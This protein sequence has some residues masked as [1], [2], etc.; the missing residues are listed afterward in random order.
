MGQDFQSRLG[1]LC[2]LELVVDNQWDLW[3]LVD[4]VT[5]SHDQSWD[6]GCGQSGC[7]C[8]SA[9][10][11]IDLSV[12]S[13]PDLDGAEH[14]TSS[15][16]VSEGSLSGSVGTTSVNTGNTSNGSTSS[17]GLGSA[18][19]TSNILDGMWLAV[20]LVQVCVDKLDNIRS[21]G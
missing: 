14:S 6:S 10:V 20:V 13:S 7:N 11:D 8:E 21:D 17:P 18:L 2:V 15:A 16:H 5:S 9:L 1:L 4:S 12:P 3:D 19:V